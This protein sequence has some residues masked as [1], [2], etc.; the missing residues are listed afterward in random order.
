M[1]WQEYVIK[2]FLACT[3]GL[4]ILYLLHFS[5]WSL[6]RRGKE[7]QKDIDK[8]LEKIKEVPNK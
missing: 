4:P 5:P 3:I 7:L 2:F 1:M 8:I 6:K